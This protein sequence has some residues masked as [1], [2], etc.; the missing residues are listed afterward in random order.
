MRKNYTGKFK[1]KVVVDVI[2]ENETLAELSSKYQVHRTMLNRWKK[3]AIE[4]LPTLF[5][6]AKKKGQNDTQGLIDEL[7]KKIGQL[8]VENDWLK[9]KVNT[10]NL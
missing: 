3:E 7:Y 5:S 10:I 4:G 1:A 2:R 9:K 6:S 8:E